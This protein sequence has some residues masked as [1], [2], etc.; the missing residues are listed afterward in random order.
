GMAL[1]FLVAYFGGH[2]MWRFKLPFADLYC[3]EGLEIIMHLGT[4]LLTVPPTLWN[5]YVA[6]RDGTGK[7]RTLWEAMRPLVGTLV[8]FGLMI[9]WAKYSSVEIIQQQP[10]LF[11]FLTGTLFSNIA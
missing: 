7:K 5:I 11:Y 1:L 6:S 4:I 3:A 8:L 9:I 2:E 10:R